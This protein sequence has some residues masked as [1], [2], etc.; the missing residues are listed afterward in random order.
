MAHI[1]DQH[2]T[3][4]RSSRCASTAC[5]EVALGATIVSV[6]D[7]KDPAVASLDFPAPAWNAFLDMLRQGS[8][9]NSREPGDAGR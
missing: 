8:T 5:I 2:R 9:G 4:R 3:W 7:S 6:R 1:D